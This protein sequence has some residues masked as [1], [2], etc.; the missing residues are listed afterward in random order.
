MTPTSGR[1]DPGQRWD[2][3]FTNRDPERVSWHQSSPETSLRL[4][5]TRRRD[6]ISEWATTWWGARAVRAEEAAQAATRF[7]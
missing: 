7:G 6:S 1:P 5:E 3:V 2:A 4:L